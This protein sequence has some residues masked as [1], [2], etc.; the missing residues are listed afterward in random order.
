M[1]LLSGFN[2]VY[3][4]CAIVL[5]IAVGNM[6]DTQN[7][8]EHKSPQSTDKYVARNEPNCDKAWSG[9][10][11]TAAEVD[12]TPTATDT[13]I[14][15][16][17]SFS[18]AVTGWSVSNSTGE[19][20]YDSGAPISGTTTTTVNLVV[21]ATCPDSST[22]TDNTDIN[23]EIGCEKV[24]KLTLFDHVNGLFKGFAKVFH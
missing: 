24:R 19:V 23:L 3:G 1:L 10:V 18:T 5:N 11:I 17:F 22:V 4:Q 16:V 7:F 8:G 13:S 14:D 15:L 6:Y 2:L 12:T 9:T 20:S 21:T